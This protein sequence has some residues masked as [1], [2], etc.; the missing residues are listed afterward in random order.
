MH[1]C[2][3]K[4]NSSK[5]GAS[6][7]VSVSNCRAILPGRG[8]SPPQ[9]ELQADHSTPGCFERQSHSS[10]VNILLK[11]LSLPSAPRAGGVL[12]DWPQ[13]CSPQPAAGKGF[14]PK[15]GTQSSQG[16]RGLTAL[17]CC[18][19]EGEAQ[20]GA[21]MGSTAQL[22]LR[23][24]L[25]PALGKLVSEPSPGHHPHPH[26]RADTAGPPLPGLGHKFRRTCSISPALPQK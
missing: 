24:A 11:L 20:K 3:E 22:S 17:P 7:P 5:A 4:E 12:Q 1:E 13:S 23:A 10:T 18:L 2:G 6:Q 21:T 19:W 8:I 9:E 25:S 16:R 14:S 15:A 26:S